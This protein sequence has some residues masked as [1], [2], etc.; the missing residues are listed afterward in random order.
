[1]VNAAANLDLF[2]NS[3]Q[4]HAYVLTKMKRI[5]TNCCS[6][7]CC[8][9]AELIRSAYPEYY[10]IR[11]L[12]PDGY[13]DTRSVKGGHANITDEEIDRRTFFQGAGRRRGSTC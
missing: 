6:R 10:E 4:I 2:A 8:V 12:L 7:R 5:A 11:L 9:C 3:S 13:E 1:M